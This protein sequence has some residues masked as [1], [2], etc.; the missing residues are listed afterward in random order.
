[1]TEQDDGLND[2]IGS[3]Q[4]DLFK[5][6]KRNKQLLTALRSAKKIIKELHDTN[7]GWE[8]FQNV[9]QMQRINKALKDGR[10][11]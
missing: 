5:S 9:P 10:N 6:N 1:M 4:D 3:L 8:M 11:I 2:Y 7:I